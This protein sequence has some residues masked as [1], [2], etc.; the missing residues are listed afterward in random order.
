MSFNND[1]DPKLVASIENLCI[2]KR[3]NNSSKGY[4]SESEYKKTQN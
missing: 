4:K 2:T 1:V 3:K